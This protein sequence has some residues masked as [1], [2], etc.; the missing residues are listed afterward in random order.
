MGVAV[1]GGASPWLGTVPHADLRPGGVACVVHSGSL[2]EALLHAGPRF[3]L[4]VVVS[5]GNEIGARR[6]RLA[7][8]P[9]GRRPDDGHRPGARGDPADP[10][11]FAEALALAAQCGQARDRARERPLAGGLP[12]GARALAARSSARRRRWRRCARHTVHHRGRRA[13]LARAPRGV[14]SRRATARQP[15]MVALTNSGGEGGLVADAAESAG[16]SSRP[17]RATSP[18]RWPRPTPGCR[19]ATRSTTGPSGLPRSSRRHSRGR[20]PG[21]PRSTG[22]CSSPSSRCATDPG[23]SQS[24]VP[25]WTRRSPP[26]PRARSQRSSPA[27]RP[28]PTPN[29]CARQARPACRCSRAT[30]RRCAPSARWPAGVPVPARRSTRATHR[31]CPSSTARP[32]TCRSTRAVRCSRATASQ[33][34]ASA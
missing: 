22:C 24:P 27:P 14:R 15:R 5:S 12:R 28:T 26:P 16:L 2:G 34:R 32:G 4:R 7:R 33:G 21:M 13:R 9:R 25:P 1:P 23:S 31:R 19:P 8:H 20:S 29:R 11:A 18:P 3:G 6:R 10:P 17:C 30:G